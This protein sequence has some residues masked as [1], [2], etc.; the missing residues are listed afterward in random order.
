MTDQEHADKINQAVDD[1]NK[2]IR[3]ASQNGLGVSVSAEQ[4]GQIA[5]STLSYTPILCFRCDIVRVEIT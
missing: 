2:A 1:L 3:G 4:V 5:A